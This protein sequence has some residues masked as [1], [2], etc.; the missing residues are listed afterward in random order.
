MLNVFHCTPPA[1]IH[2]LFRLLRR[3]HY[4]YAKEPFWLGWQRPT[5]PVKLR[6]RRWRMLSATRPSRHTAA[7]MRW[8]SPQVDGSM[9]GILRTT[10]VSQRGAHAWRQAQLISAIPTLKRLV[11][12]RRFRVTAQHHDADD[13]DSH[14]DQHHRQHGWSSYRRPGFLIHGIRSLRLATPRA[15]NAERPTPG[16]ANHPP[17]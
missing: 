3:S 10:S 16:G 11:P 17:S 14:S 12:V 7:A 5:S 2:S 8:R 9:G 1:S 13:C 6:R 4:D 15:T